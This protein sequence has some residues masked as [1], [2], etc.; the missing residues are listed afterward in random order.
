[1]GRLFE[2]EGRDQANDRDERAADAADHA[3]PF[4]H[5]LKDRDLAE[6]VEPTGAEADDLV[7]NARVGEEAGSF[8]VACREGNP[9]GVPRHGEQSSSGKE[10]E[11][12]EEEVTE[13]KRLASIAG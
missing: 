5:I 8:A 4:E 3:H 1:M 11:D 10:R 7:G 12:G 9:E 13:I 6:R 2:R